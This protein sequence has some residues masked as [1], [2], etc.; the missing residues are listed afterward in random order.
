MASWPRPRHERDADPRL[1]IHH[2]HSPDC[3]GV[4][5]LDVASHRT[6]ARCPWQ[7]FECAFFLAAIQRGSSRDPADTRDDVE[8]PVEGEDPIDPVAAHD[9]RVQRVASGE[10]RGSEEDVPSGEDVA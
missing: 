5:S 4:E 7:S 1:L 10:T 8:P 3:P 6:V 9:G 2:R